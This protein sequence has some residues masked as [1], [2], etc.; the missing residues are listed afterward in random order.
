VVYSILATVHPA[1]SKNFIL[2]LLTLAM[3][4]LLFILFI[5]QHLCRSPFYFDVTNTFTNVI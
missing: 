1:Q 5:S 4:F 2:A 3:S